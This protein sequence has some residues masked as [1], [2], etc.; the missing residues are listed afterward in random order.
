VGNI[1]TLLGITTGFTLQLR[2]GAK[3]AQSG[4]SAAI[5]HACGAF[6]QAATVAINYIPFFTSQTINFLKAQLKNHCP[7]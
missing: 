3:A 2:L 1:S 5:P 4:V 7:A 6:L